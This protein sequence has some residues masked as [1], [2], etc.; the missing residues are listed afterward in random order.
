MTTDTHV[1]TL[2]FDSIGDLSVMRSVAG[3]LAAALFVGLVVLIS[4]K[5]MTFAPS[6]DADC[7]PEICGPASD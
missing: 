6:P 7:L 1:P 3:N 5:V 4:A 2:P